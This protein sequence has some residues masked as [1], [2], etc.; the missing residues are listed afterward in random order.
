MDDPWRGGNI[1]VYAIQE[2][3]SSDPGYCGHDNGAKRGKQ[4]RQGGGNDGGQTVGLLGL[5]G[6]GTPLLLSMVPS[7]FL[8]EASGVEDKALEN[9]RGKRQEARGRRIR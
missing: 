1:A 9:G 2:G 3:S 7:F 8:V 5:P 4:A 6:W